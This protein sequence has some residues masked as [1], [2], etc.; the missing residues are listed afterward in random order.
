M[1]RKHGTETQVAQ[2]LS[3]P[4]R[5]KARRDAWG[6][7]LKDGD[8]AHNYNSLKNGNGLLIPQ[9]GKATSNIDKLTPCPFCKA[10]YKKK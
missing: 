5:S 4:I 2:I 8:F 10:L 7:L 3:L 6:L 9:Y 1:Q